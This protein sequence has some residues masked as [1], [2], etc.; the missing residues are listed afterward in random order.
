MGEP[1]SWVATVVFVAD[2]VLR[3]GLSVRVIMR[4]APVG[5]S[6]AWLAVILA[7]PF[8]GAAVYLTFGELRLGNRRAQWAATIH[9]AYRRWIDEL[10]QAYRT[11]PE[12]VGRE[13]APL[14]R[15]IDTAVGLPAVPGNSL[16]LLSDTDAVFA[17]LVADID[18]AQRTCHFE[19]YIWE[20]GGRADDVADALVRAAKRGVICRVL[21]DAVGGY[22]FLKSAKAEELRAAGVRVVP[23]LPVA[24]LRMLFVRFDLRLHRKIVVIDG[25][26]AYTGSFN[27][28][29]PRFFKSDAGV[30]RWVDALVR[31]RGP[32]VEGL[33]VTFLEDWELDSSEAVA[34]LR[35]TGDVHRLEEAG[36][37]TVQVVPSGPTIESG[38]ITAILL[39]AIYEARTELVLT[40]PY[41]VPDEPLLMALASAA[42]R[43]V[44][45]T[46]VV[47]ER[48]DS[49]L[50]SLASQTHQ[51]DLVLAGVRVMLFRD[52][53][54]H[55]K[56]ALIDGRLALFGSLNLD[57]RSLRLNYEITLAVYDEQFASRLR[58][59]QQSYIDRSQLMDLAAWR[60]RPARVRFV[61]NAVRLLSPL[62]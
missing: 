46:L 37:S 45:V 11:D 30:G 60:A 25:E 58:A 56:S 4:R 38:A 43:G 8:A 61:E 1:G 34:E 44:A 14:C 35:N 48:V 17:S 55:T 36:R 33:A 57:P 49:R 24:L 53:L 54:L 9:P 20:T 22:R 18:A 27:L 52:G 7:F 42:A 15:M 2:L 41:F 26:V 6:L 59:L 16:E 3:V 62:L 13:F 5:V 47:P 32:A 50:V 31:V 28:V 10:R 19:F 39:T 29:D 21:I 12:C 51:G 23:S 40:T